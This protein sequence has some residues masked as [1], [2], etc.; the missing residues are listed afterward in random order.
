MQ[1]DQGRAV[2]TLDGQGDPAAAD[3]FDLVKQAHALVLQ[4]QKIPP[5]E[6]GQKH[7]GNK[8]ERPEKSLSA[9][10]SCRSLRVALKTRIL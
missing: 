2:D 8:T 9:A 4:K 6:T 7:K 10:Y 1:A 3:S 5:A